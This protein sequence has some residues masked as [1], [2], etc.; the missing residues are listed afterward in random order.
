MSV[1]FGMVEAFQQKKQ[2]AAS[3]F[4]LHVHNIGI[5]QHGRFLSAT[6]LF[7]IEARI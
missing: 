2:I 1:A 3:R 5:Q 7:M 6:G 4:I